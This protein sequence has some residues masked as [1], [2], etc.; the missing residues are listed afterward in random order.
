[1]SVL[2]NIGRG[3][4]LALGSISVGVGIALIGVVKGV[5]ICVTGGKKGGKAYK[6]SGVTVHLA[7]PSETITH[8]F[9]RS[10]DSK[11]EH[12]TNEEVVLNGSEK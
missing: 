10:V 7:E 9:V 6:F 8:W 11:G 5:I 12:I 2:K 4:M 1:M 3:F